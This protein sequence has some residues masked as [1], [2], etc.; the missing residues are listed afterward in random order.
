[1]ANPLEISAQDW[2]TLNERQSI[3]NSKHVKKRLSKHGIARHAV[4]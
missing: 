4:P 2:N 1:M 3:C